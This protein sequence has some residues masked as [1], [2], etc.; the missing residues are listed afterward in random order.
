MYARENTHYVF[1]VT[2]YLKNSLNTTTIQLTVHGGSEIAVSPSTTFYMN[3]EYILFFDEIEN[4]SR[5]IGKHIYYTLL[6]SVDS[7]D[8]RELQA[9]IAVGGGVM[10]VTEVPSVKHDHA[11]VLPAGETEFF[12]TKQLP[13]GYIPNG[14]AKEERMKSIIL[15]FTPLVCIILIFSILIKAKKR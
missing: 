1:N 11:P 14:S 12:P 13:P 8:I 10:S 3:I 5:I 9:L 7:D 2:E 6:N 15:Q 4:D